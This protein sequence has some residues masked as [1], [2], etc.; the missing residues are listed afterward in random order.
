M[1]GKDSFLLRNYQQEMVS[2][3]REAWR[4][5]RSVMVQMPTGTGKT[6][7]LAEIV[8][9]FELPTT[10]D[11][12]RATSRKEMIPNGLLV[13][14]SSSPVTK[15][16]L[17]VAHR[18]ELIEQIKETLLKLK[19]KSE[20]LKIKGDE[21][22][23][24]CEKLQSKGGKID[25]NGERV[26][27]GGNVIR[28]E[29]IQ[30]ISRRIDALDFTPDLVVI[31]E[32]H[33]ALAMT[34]R[35]LWD[36]WRDAKF[37]G[38]TA[39]PC[40][41]NR[42][43]FTELF[44]SLISSWSIAAFIRQ[45]VLSP[46][47][48]FSIRPGSAD[49]QLIDSLEKRG[50]DGDYQVKE[51]DAVLNRRPSIERLYRSLIQF[52]EGKKGIV[53]AI[54]IAHARGIADYYSRQGLKS[55]AIDSKTPREERKRLIEEFKLGRI[56]VL[57]N[58][59]V[60]SEGFDCPDVEFVQMARPTLSLSKYLQQVGRGLRMSDGKECCV[61]IDNVGLYRT[62]GLPVVQWDWERMFRGDLPGKG[63]RE[64]Q[65][66]AQS[67][68]TASLKSEVPDTDAGIGLV[69]SHETLLSKLTE[70][71]CSP[72]VGQNSSELRAWRDEES[73]LWGLKRGREVV[74]KAVYRNVF[75]TKGSLAAVRFV[76]HTC[77][78]VDDEGRTIWSRNGC[79]SMRFGRNDFL[80]VQTVGDGELYIDL[81]SL[82]CYTT[83]PEVRRYGKF[84][85]LK[86][87]HSCFSR[88][89]KCYSADYNGLYITENPFFLLIH[90]S[91]DH[92]FCLLENDRECYYRLCHWLADGTIIVSDD[93]GRWY[94][95]RHGGE[96]EYIGDCS[97]GELL[98]ERV[99]T[100]ER[101]I[102]LL[103]D[104][105]REERRNSIRNDYRDAIPYQ[106]G[107][108]WGLKVGNRITVPPIYRNVQPPIGKYCAVEK[109]YSQ[110]GIIAIDGTVLIEPKYRK[111]S[112]EKDGTVLLTQVT[113]KETV[114][115]LDE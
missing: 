65:H 95:A 74:A 2:R 93:E 42:K 80:V 41:M 23:V 106:A 16:V 20:G 99:N 110:W 30:T 18:V 58:V 105:N 17:I 115:K 69:I 43:G 104:K 59:D 63:V 33:H 7:V 26:N 98:Q 55:V 49:Q 111:V 71:D 109:N 84:E 108:R 35:M 11:E 44:D 91:P 81:L 83:K 76:N 1:N 62:F 22:I 6:H 60:F 102:R 77:G 92:T 3:V 57:V 4:C 53:Y 29:S 21:P 79:V 66:V 14:R 25:V 72:I 70:L 36:K 100:L 85:L 12:L 38:L 46:F 51:M 28:V 61:L 50:A 45:G 67:V 34:Y 96:K 103:T 8:R 15:S 78:L 39:T 101:D 19:V 114:V 112:I 87:G 48:Y 37:L 27:I 10:G 52:A 89:V 31:D 73:G 88:T 90:E 94:H 64:V 40:R 9:T 56:R 24:I 68:Y 97:E 86:V 54:S 107:S 47:D 5:H 82:R 75:G 13:T 32:A 113:G